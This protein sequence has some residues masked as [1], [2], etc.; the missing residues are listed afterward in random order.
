MG[1]KSFLS[2]NEKKELME[3][4]ASTG[5]NYDRY[6]EYCAKREWKPFTR[7]YLHTW[8]H[9]HRDKIRMY[10]QEHRE[11]V[12]R[13]SMYDKE[14]RIED[15]EDLAD[16]LKVQINMSKNDPRTLIALSEQL[17]KTFE[18][19]AKERGEWLKAEESRNEGATTR[20]R[21]TE[22][23]RNIITQGT[24]T[25]IVDGRVIVAKDKGS[26]GE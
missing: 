26:L 8:V 18:A 16:E 3:F 13:L 11:E 6:L 2:T 10:R 14:R 21:L 5:E 15:L 19:I 24:K 20:D 25:Q 1:I 17:R 23:A 22:I 4:I 12:R 9:R 7:G